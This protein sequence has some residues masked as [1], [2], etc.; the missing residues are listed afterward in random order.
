MPA[1]L[2][3]ARPARDVAR[4]FDHG[5]GARVVEMGEA[6]GD[7][8]LVRGPRQLVHEALDGED[9][10]VGAERP[11]GGDAQRHVGQEVVHHPRVGDGVERDR[12]A[13]AAALGLGDRL[14]LGR[15]EGLGQQLRAEEGAGAARAHVVGVAP[16]RIGPVDDAPVPV[17]RRLGMGRHGGAEGLPGGFLLAHQLDPDRPAGQGAGD[18]RGVAGRIVGAV[19]AVAA[20]ALAVDAADPLGGDAQHLGN[21]IPVGEHALRMGPDR[22]VVALPMGHRAGGADRAMGL[23]G[24]GVVRR[25][26]PE[27]VPTL[28]RAAVED[29]R[30][31]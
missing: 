13:V 10:G 18:Q 26:T 9:V 20:R 22:D 29:Q 25:D 21:G 27:T 30:V 15:G 2:G 3:R 7:R 19:V 6:E 11:H 23:V 14:R 4:L 31:A 8:V 28:G 1:G 16:H 24:A 17:E 5:A 12:V